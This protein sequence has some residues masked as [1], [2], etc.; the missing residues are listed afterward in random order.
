MVLFIGCV[1]VLIAISFLVI[2]LRNNSVD[3]H[4]LLSQGM[5]E[6]F[7]SEF[8]IDASDPEFSRSLKLEVLTNIANEN[9][10]NRILR[11]FKE[12]VKSEDKAFVTATIQVS[13]VPVRLL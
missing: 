11:E 4:L 3:M 13:S 2:W 9:N 10:I 5:F 1:P 8:F 7:L 6:Q 12:Y